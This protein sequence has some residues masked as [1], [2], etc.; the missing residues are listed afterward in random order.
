MNTVQKQKRV[1][2]PIPFKEIGEAIHGAR[3]LYIKVL[4][5][6]FAVVTVFTLFT[7][8]YYTCEVM[9]AP[10][11]STMR[12]T[13]SSLSSLAQSFGFNLNTISNS[14][15]DAMVPMLY[16]EIVNSQYFLSNLFPIKVHCE[17]LDTTM[18]YYE[19]LSEHQK[20]SLLADIIGFIPKTIGNV[21]SSESEEDKQKEHIF[22]YHKLTKKQYSIA[23]V[24]SQKI[25]CQVD[26]K[27]MAISISVTDQN[28]D[29]AAEVADSVQK[30]LQ[31]FIIHYRTQKARIDVEYNKKLIVETKDKYDKARRRYAAYSDA[32]QRASLQS[33]H[34]QELEYSNEMAIAQQAYTQVSAQLQAAEAK[35]QQAIPAFTVLQP[36]TVPVKKAGPRRSMICL[37]FLFLAFLCTTARVLH[38]KKLLM[39][40]LGL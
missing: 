17:E 8:N 13:Q 28:A 27:T 30:H 16:P 39:P 15:G 6:T 21:L 38:K 9:L 7:P 24:L 12:G 2:T 18:T 23:K 5:A 10:E 33:I 34:T 14:S 37:G 26:K 31:D 22:N 1:T 3:K 32:N 29:I 19:Y 36:A 35:L 20:T 4:G 11:L 40:L 25:K